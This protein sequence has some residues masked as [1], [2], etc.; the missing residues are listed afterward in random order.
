MIDIDAFS[1]APIMAS[2][3]HSGPGAFAEQYT[4]PNVLLALDMA[5]K[6]GPLAGN[7]RCRKG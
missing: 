2:S 4:N 1:G 6:M 5:R 3:S 7:M